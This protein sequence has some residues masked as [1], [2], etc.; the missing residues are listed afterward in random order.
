[1]K[2]GKKPLPFW[3]LPTAVGGMMAI[4]LAWVLLRTPG[5]NLTQIAPAAS[6][7]LP[8]KSEADCP[9]VVEHRLEF[10][11]LNDD[12][13]PLPMPIVTS[14]P[15][16]PVP[17][18]PS[19]GPADADSPKV[20]LA[21]R[22]PILAGEV[23]ANPTT[24]KSKK[25]RDPL[26]VAKRIDDE[27]DAKL[28]EKSL[29]AS[30]ISND[31]EFLRR[32]FLDL[33]GR[34]PSKERTLAFLESKDPAKRSK[35][36]DELLASEQFGTT[37]AHYWRDLISKREG[38]YQYVPNEPVFVKWM[39]KEYN[40]N[41]YWNK[42]V[43]SLITAGGSEMAAGDTYLFVTHQDLQQPAPDKLAA[44]VTTLF[45]G[46]QLQCAECHVH[47]VYKNWKPKDFWGIAAF[48]AHVRTD[49]TGD[50]KKVDIGSA[51]I[52]ETGTPSPNGKMAGPKGKEIAKNPPGTV[53]IPDPTDPKKTTGTAKAMV[54]GGPAAPTLEK[55]KY[56]PYLA[57]WF[58]SS[59]NAYF[60]PA[61]VN[62]MWSYFFDK[63]FV[64]P[65]DDM[66]PDNPASHPA[67]LKALSDE[68]TVSGYDIKHLLR[69]ICNSR[70]YQRTSRSLESNSDDSVYFSHLPMRPLTPH[71]LFDS[72]EVAT[73]HD[74]AEG[75]SAAA[76]MDK[77][78]KKEGPKAKGRDAVIQA[79]DT[80]DYDEAPSEFTYGIPQLLRLMNR[81]MPPVCDEMGE[82]ATKIGSRDAAIEHL[83]LTA[84]SRRPTAVEVER[85]KS[86]ISR[87]ST[88]TKGYSAVF[89]ALLN[90]AEFINNR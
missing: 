88:P 38:E 22:S 26:A 43:R 73:G 45:M 87:E 49:R 80:R 6:V 51:V 21:L 61:H 11:P 20:N 89:W 7:T 78:A 31:A 66:R 52:T 33:T 28:K 34:I 15:A 69:C 13:E 23:D 14:E 75:R 19:A 72:L 83:Y 42:I 27:I 77:A 85:M 64:N 67:L 76:R 79:F 65:I 37:F 90:S 29:V 16:N 57:D 24:T 59:K 81:L 84:L 2:T 55:T 39:A 12:P 58:T 17:A 74:L 18:Q 32:I 63:G 54:F 44:T 47:P 71:Q 68:F 5:P 4:S 9:V 48:F 82:K 60:A 36:I 8:G 3:M 10:S 53:K 86:Y 70:T 30:P 25:G 41:P 40:T 35:L 46:N 56:R 50:K 62:R 1:M